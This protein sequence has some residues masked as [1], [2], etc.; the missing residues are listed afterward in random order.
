MSS[1]VDAAWLQR[2]EQKGP[3]TRSGSG[4]ETLNPKLCF[5]TLPA[6]RLMSSEFWGRRA[7]ELLGTGAGVSVRIWASGLWFSGGGLGTRVRNIE[8]QHFDLVGECGLWGDCASCF[9]CFG[10]SF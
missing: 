10:A 5:I 6:G 4:L 2:A 9:C 7:L 8:G 1:A 3:D